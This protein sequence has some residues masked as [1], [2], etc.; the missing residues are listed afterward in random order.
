MGVMGTRSPMV[1]TADGEVPFTA[2]IAG[3]EPT[4]DVH[5]ATKEYVDD[6]AGGGASDHGGLTGLGD[7]DHTQYVLVNGSRDFTAPVEGVDPTTTQGLVTVNWFTGQIVSF[8]ASLPTALAG[9]W[10]PLDAQLTAIAG[11]TP[12][13][14]QAI[15]WT[16]STAAA[17][18]S[19]SSFGRTL[20]SSADAT[21]ARSS[22]GLVIGTNVQAYDAEL[23][24]IAG[25]TSA[26]DR[27]PYFTGSGTAA[28]ATF[29][30]FGRSLVD[31]A[32]ASAAR[33]TLEL[34]AMAVENLVRTGFIDSG[35]ID[36]ATLFGPGVVVNS[37]LANMANGTVKA[38]VTSGTG[39]PEDV[40]FATLLEAMGVPRRL[41]AENGN[42]VRTICANTA[43][44]ETL[45]SFSV[46]GGTLGTAGMLE[47]VLTGD[48]L[49]QNAGTLNGTL[50]IKFGSTT[51]FADVG[52]IANTTPR[53]S[54]CVHVFLAACGSTSAQNVNGFVGLGPG[55][56]GSVAGR[57]NLWGQGVPA[58]V[59]GD[60]TE[61]STSA[62]TM[63]VTWKWD[64]AETNTDVRLKCARLIY[65]PGLP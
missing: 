50:H 48:V 60:A 1:V 52:G 45:W 6:H 27:V 54:L 34:G 18:Y 55:T 46:P 59:D 49:K 28:L 64:S 25:L 2:P 31:D 8:L 5:L 10:Q 16:S 41:T 51:M 56:S 12:A 9:I 32:N 33:A 44:E 40:T 43:S 19:L 63:A 13:A 22:L 47:L 37:V 58:T 65:H 29:T 42:P 3:V 53:R 14:D 23:A 4:E 17:M 61:D 35:A 15:Y 62:K 11:L 39:D 21:A 26:A 36:D 38:R 30:S 24:A 7:D 57:G 20:A